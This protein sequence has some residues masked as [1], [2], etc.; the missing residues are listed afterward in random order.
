MQ[1]LKIIWFKKFVKYFI[2]ALFW[3]KD[4]KNLIIN[5][6][7]RET[8]EFLKPF[9]LKTNFLK[10]FLFLDSMTDD[11]DYTPLLLKRSLREPYKTDVRQQDAAEFGV[12]LFE[13]MENNFD[14]EEYK[15]IKE[16]FYGM[17]KST[18]ICKNCEKQTKGPDEEFM[19]IT[20]NF[21]DN[22]QAKMKDEIEKMIERHQMKEQITFNC[23]QCQKTTQSTRTLQFSKLPKNIIMQINRFE[24]QQGV[25]SKINDQ[26]NLKAII[27]I[28]EEDKDLNY[29][30]YAVLIHFGEIPDAGHYTIY[31]K[32]DKNWYRFDDN[33]VNKIDGDFDIIQRNFKKE[34]TP[35]LLFFRRKN[36]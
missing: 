24:F 13:D 18:F 20:L 35:Y 29:E 27:K 25:R 10:C 23:E 16:I 15:Q 21:E 2:Q 31:C 30:L 8:V 4:F 32:V 33:Q 17:S 1:N 11:I 19:Y 36:N 5:E 34:E 6:F 26:I 3:T 7:K 28:Q 12:H 9:S 22:R 14:P